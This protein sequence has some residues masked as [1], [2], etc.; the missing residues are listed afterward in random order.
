MEY[1]NTSS[2][3]FFFGLSVVLILV[4]M[5]YE[6]TSFNDFKLNEEDVLILVLMEYENTSVIMIIRQML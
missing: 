2:E 3:A 5:E 1:E 6:N 4:L